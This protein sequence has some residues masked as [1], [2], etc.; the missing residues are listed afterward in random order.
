MLIFGRISI[1][2]FMR[3]LGIVFRVAALLCFACCFQSIANAQTK[4]KDTLAAPVAEVVFDVVQNRDTS[5]LFRYSEDQKKAHWEDVVRKWNE[6]TARYSFPGQ[7][8]HRAPERSAS[9][10]HYSV[11]TIALQEGVSPSGARTYQI[12]IPTAPE[13]KMAPS[14]TLSYNS[15]AGASL[16]GYGWDL[17]GISRISL[18]HKSIY[19]HGTVAPAKSA[20]P[21]GTFALD[22]S[23]LISNPDSATRF[24]FPYLTAA[25][26]ILV[27][28]ETTPQG[29]IQRF[30]ARYPNGVQATYELGFD[31]GTN[32]PSYPVTELVDR[33]GNKVVFQYTKESTDGNWRI[34]TILYNFNAQDQALSEIEFV[35]QGVQD[36]TV[37]YFAGKKVYQ[38]GRLSEII[39]R[40]RGGILAR[41][42]LR[43][44]LRDRVYLLEQVGCSNGTDSLPPLQFSYGDLNYWYGEPHATLEEDVSFRYLQ[45]AYDSEC[46]YRRGKFVADSYNDGIIIYPN[47]PTYAAI[48]SSYVLFQGYT[49]LYGSPISADQV[50]LFVP[51]LN[52]PGEGFVNQVDD[53]LRAEEGFQTLEAVDVDGDGLDEL[54]KVNLNG[55]DGDKTVLR[56]TTYKAGSTGVPQVVRTSTVRINGTFTDGN[57]VSPYC[58]GYYWGDFKG[59]G[60]T[61]L[62]AVSYNYRV[63]HP[64]SSYA[65]L[66]DLGNGTVLSDTA[67]FDGDVEARSIRAADVDGDGKTEL[68]YFSG[69]GA[70]IYRLGSNGSFSLEESHPELQSYEISSSYTYFTDMNADGYLDIITARQDSSDV[71][72]RHAYNGST[73]E[74]SEMTCITRYSW[75]NYM[76]IDVNQDGYP[77]LVKVGPEG[78]GVQINLSGRGFGEYRPSSASVT[79]AEGIVPCNVLSYG[80][81]SA[82]I[83]VNGHTINRYSYSCLSPRIRYLTTSQDGFGR[84]II[85]SYSYLPAESLYWGDDSYTPTTSQGFAKQI[86]PVYVLTGEYGILSENS[87]NFKDRL[88][89]YYSPVIHHRGLGFC[90][91]SK[92]RTYDYA[93]SHP[94]QTYIRMNPEMFGVVRSSSTYAGISSPETLVQEQE[95]TYQTSSSY[96]KSIPLLAESNAT[97][98]LTGIVSRTLNE[99]DRYGYPVRSYLVQTANEGFVQRTQTLTAYQHV[100]SSSRYILGSVAAQKVVRDGDGSIQ[101]YWKDCSVTT[102]DTAM[103]PLTQKTYTGGVFPVNPGDE[104]EEGEEDVNEQGQGPRRLHGNEPPEPD[105]PDD[106]GEPEDPE[107]PGETPATDLQPEDAQ[108]ITGL[109]LTSETRW[110]YDSRGNVLTR[111]TAPY[112][113]TVFT[114]ESFTYNAADQT[115]ASKTNAL[116]QTTTFSGYNQFGAPTLSTDYQGRTQA[117]QYDSWGNVSSTTYP[118]GAIETTTREWGGAGAFTLTKTR[119]GQPQETVHYDGLGREVRT[120]IER[121]DGQWQW[122]DK[123]YDI[124]G[125]VQKVSLPYRGTQPLYWTTY[126]YDSTDRPTKVTEPSGKETTWS[127]YKTTVTSQKDGISSTTVKDAA[128]RVIRVADHGGI[129]KYHLRDDGQPQSVDFQTEM[130]DGVSTVPV[131]TT[132]FTYDA[133]GRRTR[134]DD[135]GAGVRTDSFT[136]LTDGSSSVQHS[137]PNGTYTTEK[138][139]FGRVTAVLRDEFNTAYTYD[140][141]GR[142]THMASTNGTS[143]EFTYDNL[144]RVLSEKVTAPGGKWLQKTYTYTSGSNLSSILYT[145]QNGVIT[146][147]NYQ[148]AHGHHTGI[149]LPDNTPVRTL[150]EENDLGMPTEVT[151]GSISREY[152]FTA[153][154]LPTFRRMDNGDIQDFTYQFDPLTGNL[155]SRSDVANGQTETFTY[156]DL[157]RLVSMSGRVVCYDDYGNITRIGGVGDL[158]YSDEGN[159]YQF[160]SLQPETGAPSLRNRTVTYTSFDRPAALTEGSGSAAFTYNG[161]GDRVKMTISQD[162]VLVFSR[163]YLGGRYECDETQAGSTERLYLGG[164]AYSAPMVL[165]RQNAGSWTAYNI[166]RDYLGSITQIATL[167]GTPVAEYSY[168]PWGRLRNPVT[169]EIYASGSEPELFL[170]RGFTGHEHLTWFGLVNMNARLYDPLLGR[171]LSPDPFI[172]NPDFSQNFNRYSY[173][174]NNPLKFTD[175]SGEFFFS[176]FMGPFGA[177]LDAACWGA[178]IGGASYTV[179]VALSDGGFNNWSWSDFGKSV[180]FGALSGAVTFGVGEVFSTLGNFAGTCGT[181]LIRGVTH[182]LTQ[183]GIS[184]LQGGEFWR[185]FASGMLGSWTASGYSLLGFE[186]SLGEVGMLVYSAVAGGISSEINGGDFWKG[187]C[188][189]LVTAGLNHLQHKTEEY[190]F[191]DRLRRHYSKGNGEDFII[192]GK[193]FYYLIT[194]GKID[195]ANATLG[196]DGYYTTSIN[197]YDSGFDLKYSFGNATVKF[198]SKGMYTRLLGFYDKYDFDAKPWGTRSMLSELITRGYGGVVNGT[199]FGIYYRKSI[200]VK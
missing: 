172:Q 29:Y 99:Y 7:R 30:V 179:G 56:I 137:G 12:P 98:H 96:G 45:S 114:G 136:W 165:Q 169:L 63:P 27:K 85:N 182:G 111:T 62:L 32:Y 154:G 9:S 117:L 155:L 21:D 168:D 89:C 94:T 191:F 175:E 46:V 57:Y 18:I 14:L 67:L 93:S 90:G 16:A 150:E 161:D 97:D 24:S 55:T 69:S 141:D 95:N 171:F 109:L 17:S 170:G 11:G 110:T 106:P 189:G 68:C 122:T 128:G 194:K 77:D 82:F 88:Y 64:Q 195:Y 145:S 53:S 149:T 20:S 1:F 5:A 144:D 13:A 192:T 130:D 44:L 61:Q 164:D 108:D 143:T 70:K 178:V 151:S 58:R 52:G 125:R 113:A 146:T 115:L 33:D 86:L 38:D 103:H 119:T 54:V 116:G 142:L 22:G 158:T 8:G 126:E 184:S 81:A 102:Y 76:F 112:N 28:K 35:Y 40:S 166:G 4:E 173:V 72:V 74:R 91:F 107:D 131:V 59:N 66:I 129:L 199:S 92:I 159:P 188:I 121:F 39:S 42:N 167:D 148:W 51:C 138:D 37:R 162:S 152:G 2:L 134:I 100:A 190:K 135:P 19:Y 153:F 177:V 84:R 124:Y 31:T 47:H 147:E 10:A 187:A 60:T 127:Y 23:P 6:A 73:F 196:E 87:K 83:K 43:H 15:Q 118:D 183:G 139:R 3:R 123:V 101:S 26:G 80:N 186:Q 41:Y 200:F 48:Q 50:I 180:G 132:R 160:T 36:Y 105:E 140:N 197:F 71:W 174:L 34:S 65:A 133:Y 176:L 25:G 193:E 156:D 185:G 104:E 181:E 157:N 78:M 49:Y 198:Y 120:G 79:S 163:Y 75:D